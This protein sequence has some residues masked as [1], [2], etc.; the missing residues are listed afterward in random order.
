MESAKSL[1]SRLV[2]LMRRTARLLALPWGIWAS[3]WTLFV[4]GH[5]V[6]AGGP[7]GVVAFGMVVVTFP[8]LGIGGALAA[9]AWRKEELGGKAHLV[10]GVLMAGLVAWILDP[11]SPWVAVTGFWTMVVPPF[12]VGT[13][14]L[15]CHRQSTAREGISEEEPQSPH[16]ET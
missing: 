2:S 7:I 14:F 12:V 13:L 4:A 6:R 15:T 9:S 1:N 5:M 8:P 10:G 11:Y 16:A 3:F